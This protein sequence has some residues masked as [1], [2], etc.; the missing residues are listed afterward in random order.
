MLLIYNNSDL[1]FRSF[2][3]CRALFVWRWR[4]KRAA[5][6]RRP[7]MILR[8]HKVTFSARLRFLFQ[9][10]S[11]VCSS[12]SDRSRLIEMKLR[13]HE[14]SCDKEESSFEHPQKTLTGVPR[15]GGRCSFENTEQKHK[16]PW[17]FLFLFL[18]FFFFPT[19]ARSAATS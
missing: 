17:S 5:L 11:F 3:P 6:T 15:G 16:L 9:N 13:K 14:A 19:G 7:L 4:W 2:V 8:N 18:S 12:D 10:T 1:C